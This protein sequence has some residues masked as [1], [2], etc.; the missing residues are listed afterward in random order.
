V[1]QLRLYEDEHG[2][3]YALYE[4]KKGQSKRE[5]N[6]SFANYVSKMISSIELSV[7]SQIKSYAKDKDEWKMIMMNYYKLS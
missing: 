6:K 7:I 4:P 2:R 5:P 3:I 1:H